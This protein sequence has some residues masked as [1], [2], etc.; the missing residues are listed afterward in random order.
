M[1]NL[2]KLAAASLL[3]TASSL[4]YAATENVIAEVR[5][6]NPIT[7]T[8]TNALQFGLLSTAAVNNDVVSIDT[9]SAVTD[10]SNLVV[11]GTQAAAAITVTASAS[12]TIDIIVNN[13]VNGTGYA[14][15]TFVCSYDGGA[16]TGCLSTMSVTAVASANLAIGA[17][18]TADGNDVEGQANGSFDVVVAYQ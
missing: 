4:T 3:L 8:E 7:L 17:T 2:T 5:W 9:A 14:L 18:L 10:T 6:V 12:N 11:G 16:E 13:V 15:G 1:K